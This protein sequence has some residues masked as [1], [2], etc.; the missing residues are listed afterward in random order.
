MWA[1]IAWLLASICI[2]IGLAR[3]FRWLRGDFD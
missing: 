2:A 3:S 1:L